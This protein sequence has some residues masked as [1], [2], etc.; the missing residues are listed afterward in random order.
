MF[1]PDPDFDFYPSRILDPGVKNVPDLGSATL[2]FCCKNL[3][4]G[5]DVY[6]IGKPAV[7]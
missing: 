2:N 7:G 5:A 6:L 4:I 1:N 3:D